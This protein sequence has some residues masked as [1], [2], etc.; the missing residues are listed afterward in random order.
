FIDAS[1]DLG[2]C[3]VPQNPL[4][5]RRGSVRPIGARGDLHTMDGQRPTD[6][7]D[8]ISL[9]VLVDELTDQRCRGSH[10]RAKKPVAALSIST[11][12]S[13]SLHLRRKSRISRAASVV[14]PGATPASTSAWRTHLRNVS[15]L[16]PNRAEIAFIAAHSVS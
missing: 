3:S 10:F 2:D 12:D 1:K 7:Y 8:P 15:A 5:R 9:L 11:V 4:R 6:R 16:I 13:S 14:M